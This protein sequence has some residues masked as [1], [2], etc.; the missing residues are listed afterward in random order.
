MRTLLLLALL[1]FTLKVAAQNE[2]YL[3]AK[4]LSGLRSL[5]LSF[6]SNE[7]EPNES[8]I[9]ALYGAVNDLYA[10]K[11]VVLCHNGK[12]FEPSK[13]DLGL[14]RK[15]WLMDF[16]RQENIVLFTENVF[17][18]VPTNINA[19]VVLYYEPYSDDT[20]FVKIKDTTY[21]AD[22]LGWE[23][24]HS[25]DMITEVGNTAKGI[26]AK[27]DWGPYAA[28]QSMT[29]EFVQLKTVFRMEHPDRSTLSK[30]VTIKMVSREGK[31]KDA[32][33]LY[34]FNPL[35]QKW[36]QYGSGMVALKKKGDHYYYQSTVSHSGIFAIASPL[37]FPKYYEA[38]V[39]NNNNTLLDVFIEDP[40]A[41]FNGQCGVQDNRRVV[42]IPKV[43]YPE[44]TFLKIH[45]RDIYGHEVHDEM[46]VA[47]LQKLQ[48]PAF[49]FLIDLKNN[50]EEEK[51]LT[52][53]QEQ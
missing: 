4:K 48:S 29:G 9:Y 8:S 26:V 46:S 2:A 15:Q 53:N 47:Y 49:R 11:R 28:T 16:L 6:Q 22:A 18:M 43:P 30:P 40:R 35:Q 20:R 7:V 23:L 10:A 50:L 31:A 36:C 42:W 1:S 13:D 39:F 25:S 45:Y 27:Q 3:L 38:L 19:Q 5:E 14:Q 51:S 17:S 21:F 33:E 52:L 34:I 12:V 32:L 44:D 41:Q 24:S 37:T